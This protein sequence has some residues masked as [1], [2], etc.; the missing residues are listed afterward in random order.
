MG[1]SGIRLQGTVESDVGLRHGDD[2][3]GL[4]LECAKLATQ[5]F[6][7][8]KFDTEAGGAFNDWMGLYVTIEKAIKDPERICR[9]LQEIQGSANTGETQD[10]AA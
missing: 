5:L 3:V 2:E 1:T 7:S 8:G 6:L 4:R 9:M 10:S